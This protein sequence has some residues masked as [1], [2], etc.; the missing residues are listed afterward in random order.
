M[1]DTTQVILSND[2]FGVRHVF[3]NLVIQDSTSSP[4]QIRRNVWNM[5]YSLSYR[6]VIVAPEKIEMVFVVLQLVIQDSAS[7]EQIKVWCSPHVL[8]LVIQDST[9]SP[10]QIKV[11]CSPHVLHLVIQDST[12]SPEQ[13]NVWCSPHVLHLLIQDSTSSPE[14]INV[15]CSPHVLHLVIQNSTSSVEV[16]NLFSVLN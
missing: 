11:W 12:S 8:H 13:I 6:T 9:S 5:F 1:L 10:E 15:W 14:Q 7:P 3:Y 4:E 2:Q 16:S